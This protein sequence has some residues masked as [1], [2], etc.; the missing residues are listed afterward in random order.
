[1]LA[2]TQINDKSELSGQRESSLD[3]DKV[4]PD[5]ILIG[6]DGLSAK[7]MSLYGYTRD[8]TPYINSLAEVSLVAENAFT[9]SGKTYGSIISILTGK[10]PTSTRVINP[11]DILYGADSYQHL[12]GFLKD[13]GYSTAQIG[14][15]FWV[16]ANDWNLQNGFNIV[17]QRTFN[18]NI[19]ITTLHQLGFELPALF[20]IT[21]EERLTNRLFHALYIITIQNP[22]SVV[23]DAPSWQDDSRRIDDLL[24]LMENTKEPLFVH[25]HLLGTHGQTFHPAI[26]KF[27]AEQVQNE[28]WMFDFYDDAILTYDAYVGKLVETLKSTGKLDQTILILYTDHAMAFKSNERIPLLIHFP[29]DKYQGR[30]QTNV[31]NLDIAPTL[32]DYLDIPIPEWME[33]ESILQFSNQVRDPLFAI[34]FSGETV[35][36]MDPTSSGRNTTRLETDHHRFSAIQVFYCQR[37]YQLNLVVKEWVTS[38]VVQH[39]AP[40]E[41]NDLLDIAQIKQATVQFLASQ[42]YDTSIVP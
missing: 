24:T 36:E 42:D 5:I 31:Q 11:P 21:I 37:L 1:V 7:N 17:N 25:V 32:L 34:V 19:L 38:D 23:T 29:N 20:T 30:I 40:C 13:L 33:G 14:I 2:V 28:D 22:I 15:P 12:P 9:N 26:N 41:E 4:L 27:S 10:M 3:Y 35:D 39:T 16:D 8:T 6:S 18:R